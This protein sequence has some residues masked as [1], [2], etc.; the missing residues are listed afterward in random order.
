[1]EVL[2]AGTT[3]PLTLTC[4]VTT[5]PS[6]ADNVDVTITWLRGAAQLSNS[7][8]RISITPLSKSQ[9]V[10]TSTLTVYPLSVLDA[11]NFT[12]RAG[13]VPL[14]AGELSSTTA[15]DLGE[16]NVFIV[17]EGELVPVK[18]TATS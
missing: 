9:S 16:G 4:N 7:T 10:F 6:L 3:T 18:S 5:D 13:I 12:C 2:Y 15:S 14:S 17:V 8:S 1:M 11:T